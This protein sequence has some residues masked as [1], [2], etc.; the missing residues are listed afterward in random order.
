[1]VDIDKMQYGFTPRRGT[2]FVLRG[3]SENFKAKNKNLFFVYVDLE[4]APVECQGKLFVL[5]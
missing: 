1:M 2:A 4:K 5:L 3:L